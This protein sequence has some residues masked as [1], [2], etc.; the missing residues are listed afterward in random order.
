MRLIRRCVL[1]LTVLFAFTGRAY[2]I[3]EFKNFAIATVESCPGG[4][5]ASATTLIVSAADATRLP[6]TTNFNLVWFNSRY[7]PD[8][9]PD[10][11]IIRCSRSGITLTCTGTDR[12]R[13]QEGT[14]VVS[15]NTAGETYKIDAT[16]TAKTLTE[17]STNTANGVFTGGITSGVAS[18]T[19]KAQ[20]YGT[21]GIVGGAAGNGFVGIGN[22]PNSGYALWVDA[23]TSNV[24][25]GAGNEVIGAQFQVTNSPT[26]ATSNNTGAFGIV[27][28]GNWTGSANSGSDG[29]VYGAQFTGQLQGTP[30]VRTIYG[31]EAIVSDLATSGTATQA[32][33]L[34]SHIQT[35]AGGLIT[36]AR[37]LYSQMSGSGV[38]TAYGLDIDFGSLSG[39]TTAY[40]INIGNISQGV[41]NYAIKTGLGDV[42]FG[43]NVTTPQITATTYKGAGN[44]ITISDTANPASILM[45]GKTGQS[46]NIFDAQINA[47]SVFTITNGGAVSKMG[48]DMSFGTNNALFSTQ[49]RVGNG[50]VNFYNSGSINWANNTLATDTKDIGLMRTTAGILEVNSSSYGVWRDLIVRTQFINGAGG[51]AGAAAITTK[52]V[53]ALADA[54]ASTIL[55]VVIPNAA[56]SANVLVRVVGSLG[57]GGAIGANEASA[58]NSYIVT[59]T[60]TAGVNAV[61]AISSAF[62]SAA[63]N[64]AGA[65]TVTATVDL[66][67]VSGAVGASNTIPIRV[68]ITKSGGS[69]ASHTCQ[70]FAE[71]LNANATGVTVS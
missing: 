62:A 23:G 17:I 26:S 6:N 46:Q 42:S 54:T 38:T 32:T 28:L 35:G 12:G 14:S 5:D 48:G 1:I 69:S 61:A 27:T 43:G 7:A 65:A 9:D 8:Q 2:A 3:D 57:A 13:G 59:V 45:L 34:W 52:S 49:A 55:N 20:F 67:S 10:R 51:G 71:V 16:L 66:G 25:G 31:A 58:S 40:G 18:T 19:S 15:H 47:V 39:A 64:V 41:T 4:C 11:E 33:A 56:H 21:L 44:I 53:A 36:T 37:T 63:S 68:T 50:S 29:L 22:V 60:R 70:V 24:T 30:S